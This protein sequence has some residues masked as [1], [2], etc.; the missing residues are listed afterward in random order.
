MKRMLACL[1]ILLAC[2]M[3]Q[4]GNL[5]FLLGDDKD[6]DPWKESDYK[7]PPFPQ[8]ANLIEFYVGPAETAKFYIDQSSIDA[9]HDDGVVR[10]T[11]VVKTAGGATNVSYEGIYCDAQKLRI[12]ATGRSDGTWSEAR[13][14][15][16]KTMTGT[17]K[18]ELALARNYFC[19]NFS[20]IYSAKEGIRALKLGGNPDVK[21]ID[22][23]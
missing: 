13:N 12:Y 1:L 20:P 19:P 23:P 15:E 4:A 18:R 5:D 6:K 17:N 2:R 11:M 22:S 10:Y 9:G 8:D 7:L 3:A 21:N 14:S 16:W